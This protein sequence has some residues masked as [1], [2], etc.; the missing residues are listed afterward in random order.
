MDK[1]KFKGTNMSF[2]E[3]LTSARMARLKDVRD[4]YGFNKIWTSESKIM[5]ME[6]RSTSNMWIIL[7]LIILLGFLLVF[8]L[9]FI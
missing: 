3:T 9:G 1:R 7:E 6:E 4:E 2:P 5:V 8:F